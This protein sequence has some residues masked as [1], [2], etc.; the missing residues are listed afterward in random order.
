MAGI[1]VEDTEMEGVV[2]MLSTI[3]QELER[4]EDCEDLNDYIP[5]QASYTQD[6]YYCLEMCKGVLARGQR[7]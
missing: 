3:L 2:S 7:V 4:M 6:V 1:I 5:L